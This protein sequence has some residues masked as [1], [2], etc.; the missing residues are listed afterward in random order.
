MVGRRQDAI[1]QFERALRL[2][3]NMAQVHVNLAIA[4]AGAGRAGEAEAQLEAAK[5]LGAV[6]PEPDR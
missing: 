3:P 5:R 6:V 1:A 4:L 2:N